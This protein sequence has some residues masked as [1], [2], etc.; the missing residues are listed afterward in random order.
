MAPLAT[1]NVNMSPGACVHDPVP[2]AVTVWWAYPIS[3]N[4]IIDSMS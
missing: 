4:G 2:V 3:V 1:C